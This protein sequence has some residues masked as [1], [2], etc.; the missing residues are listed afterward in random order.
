MSSEIENL[1]LLVSIRE[2]YDNGKLKEAAKLFKKVDM[3]PY[4]SCH[5][6]PL[7]ADDDKDDVCKKLLKEGLSGRNW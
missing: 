6:C 3:C 5:D 7:W 4:M 1:A 2:A